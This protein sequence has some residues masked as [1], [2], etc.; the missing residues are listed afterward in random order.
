MRQT[1]YAVAS[2]N[3]AANGLLS[4]QSPEAERNSKLYRIGLVWRGTFTLA[5]ICR[6]K[7]M[8]DTSA[9]IRRLLVRFDAMSRLMVIATSSL[10]ADLKRKDLLGSLLGG[11]GRRLFLLRPNHR[12]WR[13]KCKPRCHG[14]HGYRCGPIDRG[15][16]LAAHWRLGPSYAVRTRDAR[17][18]R[19]RLC[20]GYRWGWGRRRAGDYQRCRRRA[21]SQK[22][23]DTSF[24]KLAHRDVI[25]FT[26][27]FEPLV[28][29]T[30]HA[31]AASSLLL[32]HI[33]L[34]QDPPDIGRHGSVEAP[35]IPSRML[36]FATD[37]IEGEIDST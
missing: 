11:L 8:Q 23:S 32:R 1:A 3:D 21:F 27:R 37:R 4:N 2:V 12:G 20:D 35:K 22:V 13:I 19:S 28:R 26:K 17:R 16:N 7:Q 6:M 36:S 5:E 24:H 18:R 30:A 31:N 34:V 15:S 9:G 14:G 10:F 25:S 33:A 29:A